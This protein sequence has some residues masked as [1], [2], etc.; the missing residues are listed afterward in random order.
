MNN[1]FHIV[2]A[3]FI[4]VSL[5]ACESPPRRGDDG[6]ID[7]I[8][9]AEKDSGPENPPD[10]SHLPE[11]VPTY[12]PRTLAGNTSPYKVSGTVY[13]VMEK[14]SGYAEEGVA[15][16]Y[17]RK[18]HGK[19]TANGERYDM[20]ALTAAHPRLPLPSFV[21]VTNL[22]NQRSIIVR[23]NDRGPFAHN[24]VIDLS[25]AGAQKL[26]YAHAGTAR[27]RVE[28]IDTEKSRAASSETPL[29]EKQLESLQQ[30]YLQLGAFAEL[31]TANTL[32]ARIAALTA[33]PVTVI[34]GLNFDAK[35]IFR[36]HVGPLPDEELMQKLSDYFVEEGFSAPLRV[37]K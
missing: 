16:W 34:E 15:S 3:G 36:V 17:G 9:T 28:Y 21:R 1:K 20:Y 8:P 24:R 23:V 11:V 7:V 32:K 31:T 13:H 29:Q 6:L 37:L 2:V 12:E 4:L 35:P 19:K 33:W 26:G 14:A 25:Y 30:N 10:L 22:D 27:V 18:F 5:G